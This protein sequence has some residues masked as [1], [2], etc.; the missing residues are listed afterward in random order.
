MY[1]LIDTH[2]HLDE[3]EALEESLAAAKVAGVT[4]IIA[5]GTDAG[6]NEKVLRIAGEH[7]GFVY[8]ALGLHPSHIRR[9]A[10]ERTLEFIEANISRAV[11]VGEIGL[12]YHKRVRELA[13]K[14]LQQQVLRELLKIAARHNKPA[15]IHSRYAWRDAF[16]L[17]DAAR[18]EKA[19]FHWYTGT[20]S[21]LRD[22][23]ARGYYLS[24][25]PAVEYHDEHRRVVKEA[26][27]PGLL[28]ETD[29]PVVYG[30]GREWEYEA[31]P[32]DV[33][34]SLEGAAGIKG[35][36]PGRLAELTT[37]NALR[38]FGLKNQA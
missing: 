13:D 31:G 11:A 3:I 34:R 12:D 1:R 29:A 18:L 28:L 27:L 17:V 35:L 32:A 22:I 16:D 25:T 21:V 20:S 8:P 5:V 7:E 10:V 6:S 30:R 37:D 2:A 9:E 23:V 36:S 33:L 15:L 24:V 38:L 4:A 26:P 14:D 19:V